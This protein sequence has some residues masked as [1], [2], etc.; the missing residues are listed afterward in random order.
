MQREGLVNGLVFE[1]KEKL[2]FCKSCIEGKKSRD[3]FPKNKEINT[4]ER[5]EIVHSDVCGPMTTE[6]LGGAY[7]F[8]TFVDDYSRFTMVY[9]IKNKS[10]VPEK[11][12]EYEAY[13]TNQ[14]GLRIKIIRTD[15][16]GEYSSEEFANFLKG[17]GIKHEVTAP[18]CPEQ[19][20]VAE[21]MNRTLVEM[22]RCM[23][24]QANLRKEFWGEA[25]NTAAYI[26]N[27]CVTSS[28]GVT[29]FQRWYQ[30]IPNLRHMHIFG[31]AGHALVHSRK[32]WDK[33]TERLRFLGYQSGTKGFRMWSEERR[34]ILVRRDVTFE[35]NV[36]RPEMRNEVTIKNS[37]ISEKELHAEKEL[38]IE[39]EKLDSD[40]KQEESDV[41]RSSRSN[42]GVP[43]KRFDEEFSYQ[44]CAY[45]MHISE[46]PLTLGEQRC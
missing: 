37:E 45:N 29:P 12:K 22:A 10:Q 44:H 28:T 33:K 8:V 7:Y 20:G 42:A 26:R 16:G 40:P 19:N 11:F 4:K 17:K 25:I 1:S 27:R 46:E 36:F 13:V 30:K 9:C 32:K 21:R 15:G 6:S 39:N 2:S 31:S 18:Y 35:E 3:K 24:F 23:I 38:D 5:L 41:R 34:K 14:F 43:P